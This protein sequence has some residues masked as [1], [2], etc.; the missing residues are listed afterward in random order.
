MAQRCAS[1]AVGSWSEARAQAGSRHLQ[2]VVETV[3]KGLFMRPLL[4]TAPFLRHAESPH[5]HSL[6]GVPLIGASPPLSV[7]LLTQPLGLPTR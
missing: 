7:R 5:V 2:A 3:E 4:L 6:M 1:G